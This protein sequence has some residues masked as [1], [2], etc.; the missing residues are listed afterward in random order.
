MTADVVTVA[1]CTPLEDLLLALGERRVGG[2]PV[3]DEG[4]RVIGLV[5]TSDLARSRPHAPRPRG[6]PFPDRSACSAAC[7]AWSGPAPRAV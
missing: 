7:P 5:S 2:L 3:T 1:H 4:D 6:T